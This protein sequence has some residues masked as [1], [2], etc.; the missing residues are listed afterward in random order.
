VADPGGMAL[1]GQQPAE[2]WLQLLRA[3]RAA[4]LSKGVEAAGAGPK[5]ARG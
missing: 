2:L 1:L 4:A 3:S 5:R